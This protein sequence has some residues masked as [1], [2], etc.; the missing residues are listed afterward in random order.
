MPAT[1][2]YARIIKD[3]F[4]IDEY[5]YAGLVTG[6]QILFTLKNY[7]LM[8]LHLWFVFLLMSGSDVLAAPSGADLLHACEDSLV[9]GFQSKTGMMCIWYV[10]PCD[11]NFGDKKTVPRVCLPKDAAHEDL[12]REVIESLKVKT[13]LQTLTAEMA[14][15]IILSP[16]YPC[17]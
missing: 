10:T 7:L 5:N 11:C 8:K 15:G 12:A 13:G 2:S 4:F 16:I 6:I 14:A 9:N 17:N 3:I 1:S